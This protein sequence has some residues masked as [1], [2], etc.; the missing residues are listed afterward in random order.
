MRRFTLKRILI[1]AAGIILDFD[2]AIFYLLALFGY[3]V[4]D[5]HRTFIT[6]ELNKYR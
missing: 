6:F 5:I 4:N 2:Y 1:A 3:L